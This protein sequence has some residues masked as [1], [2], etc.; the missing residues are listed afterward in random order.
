MSDSAPVYLNK[1]LEG[2][3]NKIKK[4]PK[5]YISHRQYAEILLERPNKER[6]LRAIQSLEIIISENEEKNVID[7]LVLSLIALRYTGEMKKAKNLS[8]HYITKYPNT[9]GF[10]V[11]LIQIL[12][13]ENNIDQAE[14]LLEQALKKFYDNEKL[15]RLNIRMHATNENWEKSLS[16]CNKALQS[17]PN[18]QRIKLSQCQA[19]Y[20]LDR[21][22]D[23]ILFFEK[24][25]EE[26]P[27]Q[28]NLPMWGRD[29]DYSSCSSTYALYC[30]ITA[31]R[32][33]P[34]HQE[35]YKENKQLIIT[36]KLTEDSKNLLEKAI[37]ETTEILSNTKHHATQNEIKLLQAECYRLLDK[38]Q[39][40]RIILEEIPS[41]YDFE[42]TGHQK[43]LTLFYSKEFQKCIEFCSTYLDS[44]PDDIVTKGVVS[45][46]YLGLGNTNEFKKRM[47]EI[48]DIVKGAKTSKQ[49]DSSF[50]INEKESYDNY[51]KFMNFLYGF[52]GTLCIKNSYTKASLV[53]DIRKMVRNPNNKV[54]KVCI[55]GGMFSYSDGGRQFYDE[56]LDLKKE[57]ELFNAQK[58]IRCDI[59]FKIS[60]DGVHA[61]YFMDEN[62]IYN[63]PGKDQIELN[64][65]DDF[66]PVTKD[67]MVAEIR[68]TWDK[69]WESPDSIE[70]PKTDNDVETW[71]KI[72]KKYKKKYEKKKNVIPLIP[73]IE[74]ILNSEESK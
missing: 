25:K 50:H 23:A 40:S 32:K 14:R 48:E 51:Q 64:Q 34:E 54:T 15:I 7:S 20:L 2:F 55:I 16:L 72:L 74:Y 46:S 60:S 18:D 5:D 56:Y 28:F 19:L 9:V 4:N 62:K 8:E 71:K 67:E 6:A 12:Q 27:H 68:K 61:R 69:Y 36:S 63:G 70:L 66:L 41:E 31:N 10:H 1:Q 21:V 22:D 35:A 57:V 39:E 53:N 26:H 47:S 13:I 38:F 29:D 44:F 58:K 65:A 73:E 24:F 42:H 3:Y 37:D 43:I 52:S 45:Y 17:H 49:A 30:K 33:S 59:E 11:Q